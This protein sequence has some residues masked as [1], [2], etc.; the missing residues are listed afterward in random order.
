MGSHVVIV[1]VD[2]NQH[3]T[4]DC[5]YEHRRLVEISRDLNDLNHRHIVMIRFNPDGYVCS[6]KGKILSPW[7]VN[8]HGVLTVMKKWKDA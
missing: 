7:R 2:E 1:E 4:Y 6:E 5:T 8:N 3:N